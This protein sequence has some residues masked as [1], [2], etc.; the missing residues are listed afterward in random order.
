LVLLAAALAGPP[1]QGAFP[2]QNGKIAFAGSPDGSFHRV[3]TINP[4]GTGANQLSPSSGSAPAWSPDGQRIAFVT[5]REGAPEIWAMN[6]D[7][8]GE[9]R[10]TADNT[11]NH[12]DPSWTPDGTKILWAN[13]FFGTYDIW[14]M[15]P[16]G[17]GQAKVG[18]SDTEHDTAPVMSPDASRIAFER[19]GHVWLMDPDGTNEQ[20]LAEGSRPDWSPDGTKLTFSR[21]QYLGCSNDEVEVV[22]VSQIFRMNADGTG[23]AQLTH[24]GPFSCFDAPQN[25]SPVWSPSGAKLAWSGF[26][27][28]FSTS[29]DPDDQLLTMDADGANVQSLGQLKAL[30]DWQPV[31]PGYSR[32]KG[33][34]PFRA[35][36]VPAYIVCASPNRTH[37][38]PLAFPSCSPPQQRSAVLTTGTPDAN[39][40]AAN[41][42]G[43]VRLAALVGNPATSADEADV[44]IEISITDVRC[45]AAGAACPGGAGSDFTGRLLAMPSALRITD[46]LNT[47]P[48]PVG[49][50]GTG[51]ARLEVPFGCTATAD[52]AVGSTC[53][54]STTVDSVVPGAVREGKRAVWEVGQIHVR[55][56]GPNGTG[57][58]SPACPP[59]CGDGD[60]T[61]FLREGVFVP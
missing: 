16:D 35:S 1:A 49:G 33:A 5:L 14:K 58:E 32:P 28:S 18:G 27:Q 10:L 29:I 19:G 7:G 60:E 3:Y 22:P 53:T 21:T 47:P 55:D 44:A 12:G 57:Y 31:Q 24:S 20:Q 2:G 54:L 59:T 61:L 23:V 40:A 13:D 8:S 41:M 52:P 4:D 46:R 26:T 34:T 36:L 15:N 11:Y 38:P 17:S 51:E 30:P 39:G 56:P 50:P 45:R 37:G 43:S 6:A 42:A 25:N 9:V 48:G